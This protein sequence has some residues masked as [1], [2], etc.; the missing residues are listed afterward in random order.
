M[1]DV[2]PQRTGQKPFLFRE[3]LSNALVKPA[4]NL[5]ESL[6]KL[7]NSAHPFCHPS[8]SRYA[9]RTG[10]PWAWRNAFTCPTV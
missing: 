8:E 1:G 7:F 10:T 2:T 6:A 3:R 5:V 4:F 9:S